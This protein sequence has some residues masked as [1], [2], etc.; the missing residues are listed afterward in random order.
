MT[1]KRR[2]GAE[3]EAVSAAR[4][5]L[6][7][8]LEGQPAEVLSAAELMVSELATN[9]VRHA[10]S[11]FEIA[12]RCRNEIRV[13][14]RDRGAGSP[15]VLNPPAR[16]I[17]GRGLRIVEAMS[18]EWGVTPQRTGKTVWFTLDRAT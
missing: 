11:P 3:A 7:E 13:E 6:R 16:E 17:S 15:T 4:H 18:D 1:R 10:H 12:I 9:S 8:V 5:F 2:F 14:V